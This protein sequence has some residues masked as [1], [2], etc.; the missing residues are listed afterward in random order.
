MK[1]HLIPFLLIPLLVV[2]A[3]PAHA[4]EDHDEAAGV[5]IHIAALLHEAK[6]L[7]AEGRPDAAEVLWKRAHEL[8]ERLEAKGQRRVPLTMEQAEKVLHGLEMGMEALEVLK[9]EKEWKALERVA[10]EIRERM[11]KARRARAE[12]PEIREARRQLGILRIAFHGLREAEKRE[13]MERME[14]AI[15]VME[16][17]IEGRR[18]E[19]AQDI[20]RRGPGREERVKLLLLA[21]KAWDGFGHEG[22]AK[23]IRELAEKMAAPMRRRG[24]AKAATGGAVTDLTEKVLRRRL[25]VLRLA[26]KAMREAEKERLVAQV[27][28]A[29]HAHELM[30]VGRKDDEARRI[31]KKA[32]QGEHLAELLGYAAHLYAQW[33]HED[34]AHACK[35][36]SLELLGKGEQEKKARKRGKASHQPADPGLVKRRMGLWKQALKAFV[37]AKRPAPAEQVEMLLKGHALAL[38]GRLD[39]VRALHA[40]V[41]STGQQAELAAAASHLYAGWGKSEIAHA[42]MAFSHELAAQQPTTKEDRHLHELRREVQELQDRIR[43]VNEEL[44]QLQAR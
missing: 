2:A 24:A 29:I 41:P 38:E 32:P 25:E 43:K 8:K 34:R 27:E 35:Q 22:K 36:L 30:L 13:A 37:E 7:K 39:E 31:W 18:D 33:G 40:R 3:L 1:L 19:E 15:H 17:N 20:R 28:Q 14:H 10:D 4:G 5:R 26:M 16:L 44:K 11:Q 42:L 9:R 12:H 21:A 6:A 23:T